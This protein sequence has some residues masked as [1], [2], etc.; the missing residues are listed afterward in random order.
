LD[1]PSGTVASWLRRH[2]GGSVIAGLLGLASL[3]ILIV[4]LV[5]I[6]VGLVASWNDSEDADWMYWLIAVGSMLVTARLAVTNRP[7]SELVGSAIF[8]AGL[9]VLA[10]RLNLF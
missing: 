2:G 1:E 9:L 5:V 6:V 4:L 8:A 3:V 7:N 10:A